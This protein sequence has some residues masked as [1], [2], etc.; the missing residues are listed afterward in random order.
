MP[1]RKRSAN[2]DVGPQ[3]SAVRAGEEAVPEDGGLEDPLASGLVGQPTKQETADQRPGQRRGADPAQPG[4]GQVP[5]RPEQR[6]RES[7]QQDLH[8][9]EG[10]GD[11]GDGHGLA[12]EGGEAGGAEDLFDVEAS[13][14]GGGLERWHVAD[15]IRE[16]VG[17][18]EGRRQFTIISR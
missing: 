6:Q 17:G 3:A 9:H 16:H 11:A 2:S 12:V 18:E 1:A 13:G 7:D 15:P 4:R 10:P 14:C 5:D 8:G